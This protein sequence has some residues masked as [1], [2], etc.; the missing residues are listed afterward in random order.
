MTLIALPEVLTLGEARETAVALVEAIAADP[1][2]V[3]DASCLRTLDS[4]AIA[5]LLECRRVAQA[6]GKTLTVTG[7]PVKLGQLAQLY[8]LEGLI[9]APPPASTP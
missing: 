8:G 5:V 7:A 2:P 3:I 1:A 6:A 9:D 4:S